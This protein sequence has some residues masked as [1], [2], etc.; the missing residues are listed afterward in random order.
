[1]ILASPLRDW[2]MGRGSAGVQKLGYCGNP[3]FQWARGNRP[4][5]GSEEGHLGSALR[6]ILGAHLKASIASEIPKDMC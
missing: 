2:R 1:M 4:E 5:C 3:N 6:G